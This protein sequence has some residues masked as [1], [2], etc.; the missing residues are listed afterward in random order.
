MLLSIY[1]TI[2]IRQALFLC[3]SLVCGLSGTADLQAQNL[4]KAPFYSPAAKQW[5]DSVLNRLNQEERIAQLIMV[6]AWSNKDSTHIREI[7]KLITDWGIGGLIFFQGGPVRQAALTNDYQSLAKVP[8]MIGI[9]GEWGLAMRLDSTIRFP[10][11]MTLSAM[12]NDSLI[13][14][15]GKE[16]GRHCKRMGIHI[17]F[18]PD[19]DVN[20]NPL[21]PV[22]GSRS[23]G[24]EKFQVLR[25]SSLYMKGMQDMKVMANAKHFPGHGNADSDSHFTLPVI[26]QDRTMLDSIELFPFRELINQGVAS[27]MVAHLHVP[28]LDTT[29]NL[30]STLSPKIVTGLL[31]EEMGFDGLIFT[32]A[33]N[34]KG[35]S[36][37]Y[38]PGVLDRIALVAGNDILLYSEDVRK[39]IEEIKLAV[40]SG[41]ITR[42]EIDARV[43]KLLMAKYWCGLN[44]YK[45]IDTTNLWNDLQSPEGLF[46]QQKTYESSLTL[47]SNKKKIIPLQDLEEM[48]IAS[49]VI[50]DKKNNAF[51]QQLATYARVELFSEEKDAP[52]SVFTAL[53]NYLSNFDLVIISMHGTT[54]KAQNNYSIPDVAQL[55]ID[56]IL[57]NRKSVFVNFGNA[58]TLTRFKKLGSAEAVLLAYEDFDIPQRLAAQAV[59]GGLQVSGRLPIEATK[60]FRRG[61]G[62][63]TIEPIRLKYTVPE[64][65]GMSTLQLAKMDSLVEKAIAAR[66]FPGCQILVARDQKVVYQKSFGTQTYT[67]KLPVKNTDLYDIASITKI[68]A[69]GLACMEL[70]DQNEYDLNRGLSRYLPDLKL[71]N[72]KGLT[73][74]DVMTHQA[75]LQSWIPFWK[76][77]VT[78]TGPSG[79][80]YRKQADSDF[81]IPV[82]DSMFMRT[83]YTDSLWQWIYR[84]PVGE[85]GKYVYSDLGPILLK[86]MVEK[87]SDKPFELFLNEKFYMPLQLSNTSFNPRTKFEASRLIPTEIDNAYRKQII[88]GYVHDP[89]AAM[90][91]GVSGN[92]GLFSNAGDLAVVMQMLL[93]EGKYGSRQYL[94]PGT[95]K[96]FTSRQSEQ[97]HNRRG[98]L[99]DKPETE[100]GKSSPT[101]SEASP[102]TFGH[103]GFT[104]TCAWADP[105]S[106]LIFIFLSNRIHPDA[107][108]DKL[109]RMNIRTELQRIAYEA[110]IKDE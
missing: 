50:G 46:L 33:L 27:I 71:T 81:T 105:E 51:Q 16:I 57:A 38:K 3:F 67:E 73:V 26:R 107:A 47:L 94:K 1:K 70:F 12:Q 23:F 32:D 72:K 43:K 63:T 39:A 42:E 108:N 86:Q 106:Q 8:L 34:M 17:N 66:A 6:A 100:K 60:T 103:Q 56:S 99:F 101:S 21:N 75:G 28:A 77:T 89:A 83:A 79:A 90:Q 93:N 22:I 31:K 49:V 35:V 52:V 76:Q 82:A 78:E 109:V 4:K 15:M 61:A 87:L 92:A 10:R 88:R 44:Q 53:Y 59:M 69:T 18:A 58:Y 2:R 19:A 65:A 11:Q 55:F 97:L 13:Y 80:V 25:K 98:L 104:G 40:D 74:R 110:I 9:D 36:S 85:K 7:R 68:T 24:D 29:P 96:L 91:G 45:P 30:P 84:S 5:A 62:L 95:V 20:N 54:M 102:A 37:C 41:E 64:D 48:R 14:L